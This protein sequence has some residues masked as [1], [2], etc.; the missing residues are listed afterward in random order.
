MAPKK[1]HVGSRH[2]AKRAIKRSI[3][4]KG[5]PHSLESSATGPPSEIDD[6]ALIGA[7]QTRQLIHNCSEMHIWR[8]LNVERYAPLKFPKPIKINSRNYWR[9]RSILDW[10]DLQEAASGAGPETGMM[11][12]RS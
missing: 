12:A 11:R 2:D 6:D 3:Q 1:S 8:L 5:R 9:R 7:R 10:L 4:P